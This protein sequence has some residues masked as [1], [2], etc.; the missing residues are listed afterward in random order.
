[1][2][3]P[4]CKGF[5]I[6][7]PAGAGA[8]LGA[9]PRAR[10]FSAAG[11]RLELT[12]L[13]KVRRSRAGVG[14][15]VGAAGGE[16]FH[17]KSVGGS[18]TGITGGGAWEEA[19]RTVLRVSFA[20]ARP[21]F[22]EPDLVQ[23][24]PFA[25]KHVGSMLG[26]SKH[27]C[28]FDDQ[29]KDLPRQPGRFAWH[30]DDEFSQLRS[31]REAALRSGAK[32]RIAHLDTG[33]DADH[34]TFPG[35]RIDTHLQR[36][37]V[38]DDRPN[39]ARD[40]GVDGLM[41]NPGHGTGTLSILAGARHRCTAPGYDFDDV[42]GGAAD[43]RIVPVRVGNSVVQ[44]TTGSVASAFA[45]IADLCA[46]P[47]TRVDVLSM[48]M[49]GV[50]SRAWAEAVNRAY[51][52]GVV[53]V[54]AAGN[55]FSAG[56]FGF[57]ASSIVYPAR[58]KRVIAACG[59]MADRKPYYGL[60]LGTMQGN[61]GPDSKMATALSAFTPNVPWAEIGCAG[62][63]DMNGAGTSAAT[64]QIASAAA[65][66]VQVHA[67]KLA[68]YPEAWMR[69]EAVRRA[70]FESADRDADEGR[71]E[72]LGNGIVRAVAALAIDPPEAS[73]LTMTPPDSAS[74]SF[75]RVITGLGAAASPADPMLELEATQL[76]QRWSRSDSANPVEFA[77]PDPDADPAGVSP[78]DVRKFLEAVEAHPEASNALRERARRALGGK[79]RARA[80]AAVATAR[81]ARAAEP[82]P[83]FRPPTPSSRRLRVFALDP[84]L[85]TKLGT[86]TIS[87]ATVEVAW[88]PLKPGPCGEYLEVIDTDPASGCW[89][90]PV[91]LDDPRLL[92]RDGLDASE[93][94][95]Q[96]HQQ[97]VYAVASKTIENF[98]HALGRRALWRPG[99][100]ND[101][102]N[103]HDDSRFVQRLRIYPHAL[104]EQNA[105]YAPDKVALLF[106][107]FSAGEEQRETIPGGRVFT[108]LSHDIIAHET[109]HALLD[110]MHRS[111]MRPS[112]PDV[113]AFHEA[114]ADIV[115]LF[116]HFTMPEVLH[117]QI[118]STRGEVRTRE[119]LL[120]RLAV[121]FGRATGQRRALRDAIGTVTGDGVWLP[122]TPSPEDYERTEEP[123]ERGALLVGAVFDAFISIYERRSADLVRLATGGSGVLTPGAI[124][125]DLVR[126]LAEQAAKSAQHVLTMCIRAL[127]YCPP[128]DITFG[129]Y[130]SAIITADMDLVPDDPH[131]YRVAFVEAF[132]KRGLFRRDL[133]TLSVESLRW[134]SPDEELRPHSMK[135][136][137]FIEGL[138]GF[139]S[140]HLYAT[141]RQK[142][143]QMQWEM[144]RSLHRWLDDHF[145]SGKEGATDAAFLGL[146][147]GKGRDRPA[148]FEIHTARFAYRTSPDGGVAPQL[149]LGIL[150]RAQVP[151]D[152]NDPK[153]ET[154]PF[155][156]GCTIVADLRS[157]EVR[158][159]IRKS[160]TSES[161]M[162]RQRS[163]AV[164]A[165]ASARA[166]YMGESAFG[167]HAQPFAALHRGG[168]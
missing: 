166:T 42:V 83:P 6:K 117:H 105:Y 57:P 167:A 35:S 23:D 152:T 141:S 109:T 140:D 75:L 120:G 153:G 2:A 63:V 77:M 92:A 89:Y 123:H 59:V 168:R 159:C 157:R 30:L 24:W 121:E 122:H 86:A 127:D 48:S 27:V 43:A 108:C 68:A 17:A 100:P 84:S 10:T 145:A 56:L 71:S 74:F 34:A 102:K 113:L 118:A 22:V 128:T 32:A 95:P 50:A 147:P 103:P 33:Y 73:A 81:P 61:W 40:L 31:A 60:S 72:K 124:H 162:A 132:K 18:L 144:R 97:M 151:V 65:L 9:S 62:I 52:M 137:G 49:G 29:D 69:V 104:R 156:G 155:E 114:F 163:M 150:Q 111:F 64:P 164:G 39:D 88:E 70:L 51:E 38:D 131:G 85:D 143:F 96:F 112:N 5:L 165:R 139:A 14:V 129:E 87:R 116:Q 154:M 146:I 115:A 158:Y 149:L 93:G 13:F 25:R 80:P 106:G 78:R 107:Y 28:I 15:G 3:A 16:W 134:R 58:F 55:N 11:S 44:I 66:Y 21:E 133:R 79:G 4:V 148:S 19:Y 119:S 160:L 130:L 47:A 99:P 98:E 20:G 91:N 138:R 54:T 135:W 53:L 142:A 110:G 161:R 126:R 45:Y 8:A 125:P 1:M 12:P 41:K 101:P 36:N 26:A 37:F 67:Q 7:L 46:D 94:T 136:Q 82:A 90:E 76:A